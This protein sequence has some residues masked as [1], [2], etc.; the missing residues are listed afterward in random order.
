MNTC[1]LMADLCALSSVL[2]SLQVKLAVA[3]QKSNPKVR[4]VTVIMMWWSEQKRKW[5]IFATTITICPSRCSCGALLGTPPPAFHLYR[6]HPHLRWFHLR[7]TLSL[8]INISRKNITHRFPGGRWWWRPWSLS[9]KHG[10]SA[11]RCRGGE[12]RGELWRGGDP[13]SNQW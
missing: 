10:V 7:K 6:L 11:W 5:H 13:E 12:E 3:A 4:H 8:K 2:H 9:T 1:S